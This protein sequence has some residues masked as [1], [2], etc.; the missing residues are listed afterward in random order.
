MTTQDA[1]SSARPRRR[2]PFRILAWIGAGMGSLLALLFIVGAVW[3]MRA[4]SWLDAAI[5]AMRAKGEPVNANELDQAYRAG[6]PEPNAAGYYEAGFA[7]VCERGKQDESLLKSLP[8]VGAGKAIELDEMPPAET[9]R[10]IEAYLADKRDGLTLLRKGAA[11]N[12]RAYPIDLRRGS[13]CSC[14]TSARCG[15]A[16][17]S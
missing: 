12:A 10:N 15:T 7:L 16:R 14:R 3:N 17:G 8:I 9:L 5:A 2:K 6:M 11:L 13:R 4:G 1:S